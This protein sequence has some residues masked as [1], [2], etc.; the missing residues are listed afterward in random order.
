MDKSALMAASLIAGGSLG[1][2]KL[3]WRKTID[4]GVQIAAGLAAAHTAGITHR[5]LKPG[6]IML[7]HDGRVKILDFGL[8]KMTGQQST[9]AAVAT[10]TVTSATEPGVVM[11]TVAYMSPEQVRGLAV[12]HRSDIF[13]FGLVLYE[14]FADKRAFIG[15]SS[16]ETMNAILKE[17]PAELPESVPAGVRTI[18]A[19]CLEKSPDNRFQSAKDLGF[20]LSQS[21]T[22]TASTAAAKDVPRWSWG[23]AAAAA[24]GIA[25]IA[26]AVAWAFLRQAP[27]PG[28]WS[29]IPLGGPDVA[30]MPRLAP[31]GHTL[32]FEAVIGGQT[33]VAIMRPEA[34]NWSILTHN[35]ERG[36]VAGMSWS[37]DG[38][39]IYFDRVLDVPRGIYGVPVL[40]GEEQLVLE[41]AM[42]P[43]AL[44]DGS[45]IVA[46]SNNQHE[47]QLFHFWPENGRLQ[48]LPMQVDLGSTLPQ[49]RAFPDGLEALVLGGRTGEAF[50]PGKDL[51]IMNVAN[52][53][54]R[55][56][57]N[58][59]QPFQIDAPAI[60]RDG[61]SVLFAEEGPFGIARL[62]GKGSSAPRVLFP[63]TNAIWS[64]D[65][66]ADGSVYVDQVERPVSLLR[67]SLK[68]GH[69]VELARYQDVGDY[70]TQFK[71][72]PDGRVV[73]KQQIA[74]RNRLVIVAE[75]KEPLPISSSTDQT[76]FPVTLVGTKEFA[77]AVGPESRSIGIASIATG[78]ITR[79]IAIDKGTLTTMVA[80][81]D[82][83]TLYCTAGGSIWMQPS[84]GGSATRLRAGNVV[85]MDPAGKYMAVIDTFEG[86]SRLLKVALSDGGEQEIQI[87]GNARPVPKESGAINKDGMLLLGLAPPDSWFIEPA[88]IDLRNGHA[89]MVPIDFQGDSFR[90]DWTAD[91]QI[92]AAVAGLR[93][94]LWKFQ[95]GQ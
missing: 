29:G 24:I 86:H 3:G 32:A 28:A 48:P 83:Q 74:G 94:S 21:G 77:F 25:A 31:D 66:G 82:G 5:D 57:V 65:T 45:L 85:A 78:M 18:V 39:R 20:A 81:P 60:T 35:R 40:G 6:N 84:A 46:R 49:V 36:S 15:E 53:Q 2:V 13:S 4:A 43:E 56:V 47:L 89:T 88:V 19:R 64:A 95:L 90:M 8:A 61:Q 51:Y 59:K 52:G 30:L 91:G 33:Q 7:T 76:N 72:L 93:A 11:G 58:R 79:R 55:A 1:Q 73:W 37:P 10:E 42:Y 63:L 22:L 9:G 75:G 17:E 69:T 44:P 67:L 54:A 38:N 80:T 23:W 14:L 41:D 34:G 26:L 27:A 87:S 12:D 16:I 68:G 50:E 62:P 92:L 70:S 71:A